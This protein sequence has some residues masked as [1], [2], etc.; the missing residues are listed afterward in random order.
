MVDN[1]ELKNSD[2]E[3]A[4]LEKKA[5]YAA[6]KAEYADKK[7]DYKSKKADKAVATKIKADE[8]EV[9]NKKVEKEV[10]TDF[11]SV[12]AKKEVLK[13]PVKAPKKK[14]VVISV[15]KASVIVRDENGKG[16]L[17]IGKYNYKIGDKIEF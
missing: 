13:E 10:E 6:R 12:E 7:S 5:E 15:D 17:L 16:I 14:G 3:S 8:K 9:K 1:F 11:K 2:F 4:I